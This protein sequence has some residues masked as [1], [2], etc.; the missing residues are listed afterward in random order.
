MVN[1][2]SWRRWLRRRR[3]LLFLLLGVFVLG[4]AVVLFT[5]VFGIIVINTIM[6]SPLKCSSLARF[7]GYVS[8]CPDGTGPPANYLVA[9]TG[10]MGAGNLGVLKM[11]RAEGADALYVA[12]DLGYTPNAQS[13]KDGFDRVGLRIPVL[14]VLGN[15]DVGYGFIARAYGSKLRQMAGSAAAHCQG[16]VGV[17]AVCDWQGILL[18]QVGHGTVDCGSNG[19]QWVTEQLRRYRRHP[20]RICMFHKV[21]HLMSVGYQRDSVGWEV[22][23]ACRAGGAII[24]TAHEHS[25][26]RT[27]LMSNF[28]NQTVVGTDRT[29]WVRRGHTFAVVTGLGGRSIRQA[30]PD[31]VHRPWWAASLTAGDPEAAPGALFCRFNTSVPGSDKR[32]NEGWGRNAECY[33][34]TTGDYEADRFW[35][36]I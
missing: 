12:G 2:G 14:A 20:W 34:R 4:I 23:E 29:L 5:E 10:D 24:V 16:V 33:F 36:T 21:Q 11:V 30:N 6:D 17:R 8:E 7:D 31:L 35:I 3:N 1:A 13:W 27:H 19:A 15:H 22:Y 18:L 9:F 32:P 28:A 26:S 25:Y